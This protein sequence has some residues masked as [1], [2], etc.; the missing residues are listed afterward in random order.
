VNPTPV[1]FAAEV[2]LAKRDI[3][4]LCDACASSETL[5]RRLGLVAE[6]D[7][8]SDLLAALEGSLCGPYAS[9]SDSGFA[10]AFPSASLS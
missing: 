1:T 6:A 4:D 8:L 9:D 7:R 2:A 5:L 10:S 3:F